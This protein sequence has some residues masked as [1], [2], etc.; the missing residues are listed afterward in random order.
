MRHNFLSL[1]CISALL[2]LTFLPISTGSA[3]AQCVISHVGTQLNMSRNR[4]EQTSNIQM[5]STPSCTGNVSSSRAVQVNIGGNGKVR[6]HQNVY[7]EM[8]GGKGNITGVNVPTVKS[9]VVVPV[10]VRTPNNFN[11]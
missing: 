8:L 1:G 3:S 11:P 10:N 4:A 9:G 6:Q 5:E 2:S 7:H